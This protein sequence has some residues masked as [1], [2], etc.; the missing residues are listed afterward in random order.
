[1]ECLCTSSS[2]YVNGVQIHLT[3]SVVQGLADLVSSVKLC[4]HF[5]HFVY[6]NKE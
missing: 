3:L 1:M 6:Y 4:L 2:R 5:S